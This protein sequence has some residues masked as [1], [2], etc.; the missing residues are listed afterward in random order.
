M[1]Y[2][3]EQ[4]RLQGFSCESISLILICFLNYKAVNVYPSLCLKDELI[5][6][7]DTATF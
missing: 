3:D 1:I 6:I 7:D 4:S 2:L 5:K